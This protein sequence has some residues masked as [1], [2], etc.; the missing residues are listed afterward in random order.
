MFYSFLLKFPCPG[1]SSQTI[2]TMP[3]MNFSWSNNGLPDAELN[4]TVRNVT[5]NH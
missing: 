1:V 5:G 3:H 4:K 2:I